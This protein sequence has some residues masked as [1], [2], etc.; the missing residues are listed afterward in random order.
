VTNLRS[1][2]LDVPVDDAQVDY[3]DARTTLRPARVAIV[4]DGGDDWHYWARL[5]IYA[6]SRVWSGAG[7][8]LIPHREGEVGPLLLQAVR[9]YDPD[10][11]V[12]L[13][14]TLNQFG[15]RVRSRATARAGRR[16]VSQ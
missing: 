13:R 9:A 10:Y 1:T 16:K 12:L 6:A 8:I 7:F 2:R 4:F 14:V 5:S 3:V 15:V 11:V